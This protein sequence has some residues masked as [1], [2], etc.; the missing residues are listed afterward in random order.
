MVADKDRIIYTQDA[1]AQDRPDEDQPVIRLQ[2]TCMPMGDA[3]II[4]E[5][6]C[7]LA[8]LTE[9]I[10]SVISPVPTRP[11]ISPWALQRIFEV[12]IQRRRPA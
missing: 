8:R 6:L 5:A 4:P 7:F 1:I 10:C 3:W 9:H 2:F 12:K 11:M